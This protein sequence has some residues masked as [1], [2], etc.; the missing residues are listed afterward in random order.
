MSNN[1]SYISN[2]H[3]AYIESL[4]KEYQ[5]DKDAIDTDWRKFFEGFDYAVV[6][7]NGNGTATNTR[8]T[9]TPPKETDVSWLEE[10]KVYNLIQAHRAKGHL[11]SDTNPI[12]P[13]RD[14][15]AHLTLKD[16]GLTEADLSK[17]FAIGSEI[18]M[19]NASL[20]D[21]YNRLRKVYC[22]SIGVEFMHNVKPEVQQWFID[23]FEAEK[24]GF[25]F[26]GSTKKHILRKLNQTVVF[27]QF[28]HTKY[29]GQKRFSLE[30]GE[31]TIPAID[32]MIHEAAST[33][34]KEIVI[35]MAH[36][37]R[38]NVLVNILGKT[39][40]QVFSEFE[41][42][43]PEQ[44]M[45]DGDVKYHLGYSSQ[46]DTKSGERVYLK[47]APNPS[48]LEA[49]NPVVE[50][51]ARAKADAIYDFDYDSLMPI[52]IHGDA[53]IAGQGIVYEVVQMSQLPG[54]YTGGTIHFVI[55]NQIGF[56]TDFDDARSANYSTDIAK[57]VEAPVIH[58]NG[59]DVEAVVFAAKVATQYRQKFN[60]DIFVDMVCYRK[61]GHNEG[62]DPKFTQPIMYKLIANHDN[63]RDLYSQKLAAANEI[64]AALAKRL[65]K[66]FRQL[67]QERLDMVRNEE[68][69]PYQLQ[70]S[71]LAWEKL[72]PTIKA[73]DFE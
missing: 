20:Q 59:D 41:G 16:F 66:E 21:I 60:K 35:G 10:L 4:Y 70:E 56:T 50:G 54:Y 8:K 39:Y 9:A 68:P 3:P 13:R 48:H 40:E 46:V 45:G 36:R 18:G 37:G 71:E 69:L 26:D 53:A 49:V 29:V 17:T 25:G 72:K 63:P 1:Y 42:H 47:L 24:K 30:G 58:V 32:A 57:I 67:L 27:E 62:D 51:Y 65:D 64:E 2:A 12:R 33:G 73:E 52:L 7:A 15:K 6:S 28:L 34:A 23:H 38:L 55:N 19:K 5:Q 43:F 22:G 11:E 44:T 31:S 61:H 14:R